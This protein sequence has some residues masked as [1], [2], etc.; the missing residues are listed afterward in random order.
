MLNKS[1]LLKEKLEPEI[2]RFNHVLIS[3]KDNSNIDK[4]ILKIYTSLCPTF[5]LSI[6]KEKQFLIL[7]IFFIINILFIYLYDI[8]DRHF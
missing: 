4:L 3:L 5:T 2:T 6:S 7:I 8:G 1:D